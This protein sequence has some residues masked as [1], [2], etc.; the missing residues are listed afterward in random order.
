[1]PSCHHERCLYRRPA[2]HVLSWLPSCHALLEEE[3]NLRPG[4][5][6]PS[7][8]TR[9]AWNWAAF[10]SA[11]RQNTCTTAA[12]R[13]YCRNMRTLTAV[14]CFLSPALFARLAVRSAISAAATSAAHCWRALFRRRDSHRWKNAIEGD[15]RYLFAVRHIRVPLYRVPLHISSLPGVMGGR[16]EKKRQAFMYILHVEVSLPLLEGIC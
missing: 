14:R 15:E 4:I 5:C 16:E 8:G 6:L 10:R 12:L 3:Q 9:W 11:Q 1:M 13:C 2:L 7:H